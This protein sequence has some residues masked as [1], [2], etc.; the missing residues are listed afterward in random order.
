MA[1]KTTIINRALSLIGAEPINNLT[2]DTPEAQIA[3][4]QYEESRRSVLS[5]CLWNFAAK[6]DALNSVAETLPWSK[7][8]V[9]N[10]FQLPADIIRIF[11]VS[12]PYATWHIEQDRLITD[13]SEIGI[14]YVYDLEDTTKFSS[15]F[16][17]AF[18]DKLAADMCYTVLNSNTEAKLMMEKYEGVSLPKAM[19][20]NSQEGTAAQVKDDLWPYAR[21][22]FA[23]VNRSGIFIGG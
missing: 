13:V 20:D 8:G 5:E 9:N 10:V 16:T 23:P 19:A 12:Q 1:D 3:N 17:D 7:D 15:S 2:D 4:R 6:R 18:A 11:E 22:G 21:F 14:L